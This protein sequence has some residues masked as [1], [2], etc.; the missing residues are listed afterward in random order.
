MTINF[1]EH[2][3]KIPKALFEKEAIFF[4]WNCEKKKEEMELEP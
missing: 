2:T 4:S 3:P 1:C